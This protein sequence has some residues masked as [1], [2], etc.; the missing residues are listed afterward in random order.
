MRSG[1]RNVEH[2]PFSP[3]RYFPYEWHFPLGQTNGHLAIDGRIFGVHHRP[4]PLNNGNVDGLKQL[5]EAQKKVSPHLAA[6]S[7]P[8]SRSEIDATTFHLSITGAC[9]YS[10]VSGK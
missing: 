10:A 7:R 5:E 6:V 4:C 8:R 3:G 1:G 9:V 2:F